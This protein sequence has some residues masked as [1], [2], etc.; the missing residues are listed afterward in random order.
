MSYCWGPSLGPLLVR[1]LSM[2]GCNIFFSACKVT[3]PSS[4]GDVACLYTF[5][6]RVE[7]KQRL[8]DLQHQYN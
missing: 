1:A 2:S 6:M 4:C 8:C 3:T 5:N 7:C